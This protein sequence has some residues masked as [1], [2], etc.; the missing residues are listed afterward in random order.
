MPLLIIE[1]FVELF[2]G[3]GVAT[4]KIALVIDVRS[5]DGENARKVIELLKSR[6]GAKVVFLA[7]AKEILL[8]RYNSSR[9]KHPLGGDLE[10][11]VSREQRMM[12]PIRE[13]SDTV[14]DTSNM[15]VHELSDQITDFFLEQ[16]DLLITVSSFGFKYGLPTDSDLVF[17]VRFIKNPFFVEAMRERTGLDADVSEYV[18]QDPA[19]GE[20]LARL[21]E[22]LLFLIPQYQREG[23]RFLKISIGCTGGK[24]R[25]VAIVEYIGRYLNERF[26]NE[27]VNI[28]TK[29][30]DM[31]L[32]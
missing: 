11:A 20:F 21:T 12:S 23:K 27:P 6:Y 19:T 31:E 30:R 1:K 26:S 22:M 24:H 10:E 18:M 32:L 28:Q 4:N 29:H 7:T 14:I 25:S 15:N 5:G 13:L 16:K 8:K 9:R 2:F 3:L 17:D